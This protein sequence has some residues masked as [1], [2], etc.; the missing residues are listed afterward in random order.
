MN[1]SR[2]MGAISAVREGQP[3]AI[4]V[5]G[6][7]K[8]FGDVKALDGIDL[9][10][11]RGMIFAIL[12]PNGAGKTTLIRLLATLARPDDGSA[13]V[14]G[15]DLISDPQ[16]VRGAI[17]LTGQF[18]S[19]DEDLTGR[20]NL[21][22]LARLWGFSGR[23]AKARADE[24]LLAFE[25]S[26]AAKKQVK[27]Y[28][29]G[30][31]RRLD[32]AASLIVTPGVLFLDEPTTGL[33]PKARQGVWKMIRALAQSGVTILLTTQYL[34]EAD[35]LAA[36]IAVID[37][38]RKIAEGTSR[39]LKSAIG[40]GFLHVALADNERLDEGETILE[41]VLDASVQRSAEGAQLSVVAGSP[42]AAN[43][44]LAALIAAGI[45]LS[46]FSM[47]SPSLDEVFFALTGQPMEEDTEGEAS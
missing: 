26:D 3:F 44:A 29:G 12:G 22:M 15:H 45:E 46:D 35:Q 11:P 6:L 7:A 30:M 23:A 21:I 17:A 47:G 1:D 10:V 13:S 18:A 8:R 28:S 39:E 24:L 37:R 38:G 36:R 34:E 19:L 27:S 41:R 33:D 2:P 9:D 42:K 5:R 43:E 14:M 25:L 20:E 16:A 32:I 4:S 40:S 31:R